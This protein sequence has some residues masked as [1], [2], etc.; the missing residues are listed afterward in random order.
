M[1]AVVNKNNL[2][3]P[4]NVVGNLPL[5]KLLLKEEK[6]LCFNRK[7]EDPRQKHSGMTPSF[8]NN[9]FTL[10]ELLVVV[11][12][13]GILAAV[14]LPQY[15]KAVEKSRGAQA[16][17]LVNSMAQALQTYYMANGSY[18]TSFEE[19]DIDVPAGWTGSEKWNNRTENLIDTKSNGEWS[20]QLYKTQD[21][22]S[23]VLYMGR[24]TGK[25]KG[26]GFGRDIAYNGQ[27]YNGATWCA[28]RKSSGV[29]FTETAGSYCTGIWKGTWN[30]NDGKTFRA[31]R[32]P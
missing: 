28:E 9:G 7:V 4:R 21:F 30:N 12:I 23:L 3:F 17:T 25:Y 16:L 5:S 1:K 14:A 31:Y 19:L 27:L 32:M 6:Q 11:L 29:I 15:Q 18:P 20:L 2:S 26:A 24:L 8:N 13:I 22:G 10:I